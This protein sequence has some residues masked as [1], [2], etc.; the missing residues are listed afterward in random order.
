[1][2]TKLDKSVYQTI[3]MV[4]PKKAKNFAIRIYGDS[5]EFLT[6]DSFGMVCKL[7][8]VK[9]DQVIL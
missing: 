1:M 7:G 4:M 2:K 3:K 9:Q 8:K 6:L 5:D